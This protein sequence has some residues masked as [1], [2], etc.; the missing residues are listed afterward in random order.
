MWLQ[1]GAYSWVLFVCCMNCHGELVRSKPHPQ[2]LTLF[3]LVVAAGGAL[4]GAAVAIAAPSLFVDFW[5]YHV[6]LAGTCLVVAACWY[7]DLAWRTRVRWLYWFP[8]PLAVGLA[9]LVVAAAYGTVKEDTDVIAISRNF[10]GVLRVTEYVEDEERGEMVRSLRHGRILHGNQFVGTERSLFATTYYGPDSGIGLALAHH[11]RRMNPELLTQDL[12]VGVV[13]LGTGTI[14][15]YGKPGDY[16]RFYEINPEVVRLSDTYFSYREDTFA[17]AEVV[18]GD[19]RIQL[20]R[21]L[22]RGEPQR[23]D[24]LAVDAFSSDA[25]PVHLLTAECAQVYW[26]HLK[27][28]GLLLLHISNRFLN[29]NPVTRGLAEELGCYAVLIDSDDNDDWNVDYASWVILTNNEDF[30]AVTQVEEAIDP[31]PEDDPK[32]IVWTDSFASLYH[33]LDLEWPEFASKFF[34]WLRELTSSR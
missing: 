29:L 33:V 17:T 7:R 34:A 22:E 18:L 6:A 8:A 10:Y 4:G 11:P 28:D 19:A 27:P 24:V 32:P 3:Y 23:F 15:A 31:W 14:V 9:G 12:R 16:F 5:E 1:I 13:G 2:H 21:E 20:E 25:I 30:L 26:Q